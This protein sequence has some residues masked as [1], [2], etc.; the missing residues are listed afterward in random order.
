MSLN[1]LEKEI[2][3]DGVVDADEVARIRG[4]LFD[5]GQ[6]DRAEADFLFNVNDA[7]S[8]AAN[9]AS[10][11]TLFV[12]AITSHL[13]NDAESPGAIDDDEAAW[14]IQRI[15]GDGQY[16]ACEKAL[17]QEVSRKATSMPAS[18]KSLLEKACS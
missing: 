6:I 2:V 9:A 16:D 14:L 4:V 7:V 1:E 11:Q 15:E 8:G 12:E 13:L 10:W 18:L 3:A 17:M 5:D